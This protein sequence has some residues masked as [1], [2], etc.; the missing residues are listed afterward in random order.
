MNEIQEKKTLNISD[1]PSIEQKLEK[2]NELIK[3]GNY[4]PDN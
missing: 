3:Q 2:I 1:L 4:S